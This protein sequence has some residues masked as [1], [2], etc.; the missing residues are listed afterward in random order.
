M[1]IIRASMR[2]GSSAV[3]TAVCGFAAVG[4]TVAVTSPAHASVAA[5][6]D[7]TAT[8]GGSVYAL[9]AAG[10]RT[11]IG[12]RF[13]RVG[14]RPRDNV[15]AVRPD[16]KVDPA[17]VANTDGKVEALAVSADGA[18]VF[19]GGTFTTVNGVARANLAAVDST[20]G[21]V[22]PG[23][24]A[25][26]SGSGPTV[27][28]LAV[29]DNRLY[30]GGR[31]NGID[32]TGRSK[33][34]ALDAT[35]GDVIM[36]FNPKANGTVRAIAVTPDGSMI[37]AGG[38]F[39]SLGGQPRGFNAGAVYTS[40]GLATP[41]NPAES[42]GS[43]VV[44]LALNPDGTRVYLSTQNNFVYAYDHAASSSPLWGTKTSGN[45][46]AIAPSDTEIYIGGHWSGFK[47]GNIK[48]PYLGSIR[49]SDGIP[50]SWDTQ[51]SGGSMGVWALLIQGSHL[52]AGGVFSYFGSDPQRGY[53]RFTGSP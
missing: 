34:A 9:A 1:G 43:G 49:P 24:S 5:T 2:S 41:F 37:F 32:G 20:T 45:T 44:T 3:R 27:M 30:V 23:W 15:G 19:I 51:C 17:F 11:I 39:T 10:D 13:T 52:H 14:T 6:P 28:A 22:I 33:L 42:G 21:A 40:N 25:D 46:Q 36:S 48:R 31:Y 47:D 53:A 8:V 29:K 50:T 35:T 4:M 12:G 38:G 18:T 16:G 7:D 26:T